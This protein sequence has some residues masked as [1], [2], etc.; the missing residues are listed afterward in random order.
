MA[1]SSFRFPAAIDPKQLYEKLLER[2][3][4]YVTITDHDTI[5]GCL[6]I[7]DR[8]APLSANKSP[9]ISQRSMQAAYSRLGISEN[10][11]R[12]IDEYA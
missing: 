4:D 7:S 5:E 11:H 10:Q 8:L 9:P 6:Q 2:G 3:M 1:L 12:E